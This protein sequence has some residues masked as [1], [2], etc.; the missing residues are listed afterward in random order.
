MASVAGRYARAFAE[1]VVENRMDPAQTIQELSNI[2][3]LV[4]SS[5]ELRNVLQNPAVAHKQKLGLLDAIMSRMG[6]SKMLRNFL[7]V[8]IDQ[9][10]IREINEIAEQFKHELN[11]R[12]GIAEAR[13]SAI[14]ELTPE[15]KQ[16]L[17][18]KVAAMTGKVVRATYSR[19]A[20]LLG[21]A[22]VRVGSTIYDGSVRGQLQRIKQ[23]ITAS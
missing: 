12:L 22:V 15:E 5:L 2:A 3:E 18:K 20:S 11:Q 9:R 16:L 8:L 17:E 21:G 14:R 19:D 6:G 10:R 23:Q 7:A 13:I 4:N 1:V